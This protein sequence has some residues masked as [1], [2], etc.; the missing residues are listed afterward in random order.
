MGFACA[1]SRIVLADV[2]SGVPRR[3][4]TTSE[5]KLAVPTQSNELEHTFVRF[6]VNE[7]QVGLDVAISVVP[8]FPQE[9]MVVVPGVQWSVD[10]QQSQQLGQGLIDISV[11]GVG[12]DALEVALESPRAFKTSHADP[13]S[14]LPPK[15]TT[16]HLLDGLPPWLRL[17]RRWG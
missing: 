15:Q 17:S 1:A 7:N 3:P 9:S 12:H 2:G 11:P 13:P 5:S 8:P 10:Q 6:A 16:Q 14:A 4:L